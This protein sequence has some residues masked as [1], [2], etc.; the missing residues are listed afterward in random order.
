MS[1]IGPVA[2]LII[3]LSPLLVPVAVSAAH[4][5]ANWRLTYEPFRKIIGLK[6]RAITDVGG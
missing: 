2:V 5:V 1:Y 6:S 4:A 3:V